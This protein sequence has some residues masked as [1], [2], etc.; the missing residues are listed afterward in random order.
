MNGELLTTRVVAGSQ[1]NTTSCLPLADDM[2]GS[3]CGQN[4]ILADEQLLDTVGSTDLCDQLDNLGVPVTTIT[5]NHQE[6]ACY[7]CQSFLAVGVSSRKEADQAYPL[8]L[9]G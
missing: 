2:A 5:T 1:E 8:H 9:L 7:L 3:G 6:G 4:A